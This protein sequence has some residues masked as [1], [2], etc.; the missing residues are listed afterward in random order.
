MG[1]KLLSGLCSKSIDNINIKEEGTVYGGCSANVQCALATRNDATRG[2]E[3]AAQILVGCWMGPV[4]RL[5]CGIVLW[6]WFLKRKAVTVIRIQ[7]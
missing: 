2:A 7:E 6:I 5:Q 1:S 3:P 4:A